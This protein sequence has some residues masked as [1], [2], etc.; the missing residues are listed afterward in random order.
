MAEVEVTVIEVNPEWIVVEGARMGGCAQCSRKQ[1]C[2]TSAEALSESKLTRHRLKNPGGIALGQA[3]MI[4]CDDRVL[5]A[6]LARTLLLPLLGAL[7]GLG[8]AML[9]SPQGP[10]WQR[11]L[12][13]LTGFI[14]MTYLM[15]RWGRSSTLQHAA[16]DSAIQIV[17]YP[18][19]TR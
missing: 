13:V 1:H 3:L 16:D 11:V 6:Q 14:V 17:N 4:G 8:L 12:A 9:L 2:P 19:A 7:L 15:R 18:S 5:L 10:D